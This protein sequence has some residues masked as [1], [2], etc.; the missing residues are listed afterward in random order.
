MRQFYYFLGV[1]G[2]CLAGT[3]YCNDRSERFSVVSIKNWEA[4]FNTVDDGAGY[5]GS[6]FIPMQ[7]LWD[8]DNRFLQRQGATY[9]IEE[10]R[11]DRNGRRVNSPFQNVA[12]PEPESRIFVRRSEGITFAQYNDRYQTGK[13]DDEAV[14]V[15][16]DRVPLSDLLVPPV[17]TD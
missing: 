6:V 8:I 1:F 15:Q 12:P 10:I 2:V 7:S 5:W 3:I 11:R 16:E 9:T 14:E 13:V 4:H 17:N